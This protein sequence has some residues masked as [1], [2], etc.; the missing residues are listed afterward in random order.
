MPIPRKA[1]RDKNERAI[2]QALEGIP[3][4]SVVFLSQENIPDLLIGYQGVNYLV[5]IKSEKGKVKPGQA[6][7]L[8]DWPGQAGVCRTLD[9]VLK[10]IGVQ[11]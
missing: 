1:R 7:F 10:I 9:E 5:E 4:L 2:T 6:R 11:S 8:M 3:G